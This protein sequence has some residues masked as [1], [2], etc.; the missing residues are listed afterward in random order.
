MV[1]HNR[2]VEQIFKMDKKIINTYTYVN[3]IIRLGENK[4]VSVKKLNVIS[5]DTISYI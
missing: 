3:I 4:L 5:S 2:Y 1:E